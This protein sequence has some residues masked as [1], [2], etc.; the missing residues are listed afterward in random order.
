MFH[1][2]TIAMMKDTTGGHLAFDFAELTVS[3]LMVETFELS[4]LGLGHSKSLEVCNSM[5]LAVRLRGDLLP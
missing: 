3:K 2:L 4:V 1:S 5:L